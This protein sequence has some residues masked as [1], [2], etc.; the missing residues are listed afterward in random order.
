MSVVMER[1][2]RETNR[3]QVKLA[4]IRSAA[5]AADAELQLS[6]VR[7]VGGRYLALRDETFADASD[8]FR[9]LE[10][11]VIVLRRVRRVT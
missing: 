8:E 3:R 1:A 5:S 9:A 11:L 10:D 6:E 7:E 4:A 2:T